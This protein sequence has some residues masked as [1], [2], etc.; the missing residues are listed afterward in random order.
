MNNNKKFFKKVSFIVISII[1]ASFF[2]II[3]DTDGFWGDPGFLWHLRDGENI[4]TQLKIPYV[5]TFLSVQRPWISDQWFSDVVLYLAYCLGS[6]NFIFYFITLLLIYF[7]F[8]FFPKKVLSKYS[9]TFIS[10][11]VSCYL[12]L[13]LRCHYF[14]RPVVFS[15]MLLISF[16]YLLE[17]YKEKIKNSNKLT[18]I[19]IVFFVLFLLWA[20]VHPSFFIAFFIWGIFV[21][22]MLVNLFLEYKDNLPVLKNE[23]KKYILTSFI[24]GGATLINPYFFSLHKSILFLSN[25]KFFMDLNDEWKKIPFDSVQ[26]ILITSVI[27]LITSFFILKKEYRK[28][29]GYTYFI[30]SI[31]FYIYAMRHTRGITYFAIISSILL[32]A[33][34]KDLFSKKISEKIYILRLLPKFYRHMVVYFKNGQILMLSLIILIIVGIFC[35]NYDFKLDDTKFPNGI[36]DFINKNRLEGNIAS[37]PNYGGFL[38]WHARGIKPII[39]DR[40]T[41]LG[42]KAYRDY[43]SSRNNPSKF[44][45]Y[46]KSQHARYVLIS[47]RDIAYKR[48]LKSDAFR[49]LFKKGRFIL[50]E[51]KNFN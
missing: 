38:I 49:V 11:I 33:C 44:Y 15:F 10:I 14:A 25:N 8:I 36:C 45:H 26:G 51:V 4:V 41:L 30:S 47:T 2:I 18:K 16:V 40:N 17:L 13:G 39:D 5:D 34:L 19:N 12:M 23:S 42:E 22:E 9:N 20:N 48:F 7:V 1:L 37:S 3:L 31:V 28:K 21:V 24:I 6:F 35:K 46:A 27:I 50:F 32:C 29:V 43:I